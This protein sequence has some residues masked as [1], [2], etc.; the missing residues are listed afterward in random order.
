MF[1]DVAGEAVMLSVEN[2]AYYGLNVTGSYIYKHL[3][4]PCRISDL[5]EHLQITFSLSQEQLKNEVVPFI[6]HMVSDKILF[7][8]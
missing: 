8:K 4:T 2:G 7:L 3:E 1:S 6:E 5:C